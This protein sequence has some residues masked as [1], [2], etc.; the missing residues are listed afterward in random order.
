[1]TRIKLKY[2]SKNMIMKIFYD[3]VVFRS[4]KTK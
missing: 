1:M 3:L 4:E 2:I